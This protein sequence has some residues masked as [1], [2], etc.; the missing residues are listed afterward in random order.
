LK[1]L[2]LGRALEEGF[3]VTVEPGIYVVP[4][5][6]DQ[7]QSQNKHKDFINYDKVNAFRSFGG[8]RIEEDYFITASGSRLLGK[9]FA[10]TA[11]DI[12][13]LKMT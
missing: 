4:E 1:S 2:R 9:P 7:W 8:I 3:V 12:E 10:K 5:L 11:V 6:I 13:A